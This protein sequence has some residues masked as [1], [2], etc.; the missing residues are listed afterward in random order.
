LIAAGEGLPA[1]STY[2]RHA[3]VAITSDLYRH[4]LPGSEADTAA[5]FGAFL[6]RADTAGRLAQLDAGDEAA[7]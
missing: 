6:E 5:R 1:V 3:S 2:M 4:M 7:A